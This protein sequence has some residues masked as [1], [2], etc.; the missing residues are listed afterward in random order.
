MGQMRRLPLLKGFVLGLFLL[1]S[2]SP[3]HAMSSDSSMSHIKSQKESASQCQT[4]C[5]NLKPVATISQAS[6]SQDKDP[7]PTEP[8]YLAFIGV[9]WTT[10]IG[11][12][13]AYLLGYLRWRPPDLFKF[14][15]SYRF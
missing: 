6:E 12:A 5:P 8:Y 9:G 2:T 11:V 10:F 1:L 15:V 13:A 14:N 7:V 4:M 3:A